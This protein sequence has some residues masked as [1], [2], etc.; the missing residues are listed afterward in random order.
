[1]VLWILRFIVAIPGKR[2]VT[3]LFMGL[4]KRKQLMSHEVVF[5]QI[6][7]FSTSLWFS[8]SPASMS[9]TLAVA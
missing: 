4:L 5:F 1:M 8:L 9:S 7:N 3:M 6:S 2:Y